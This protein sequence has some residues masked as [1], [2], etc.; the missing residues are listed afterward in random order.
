[1]FLVINILNISMLTNIFVDIKKHNLVINKK[2]L[3]IIVS[4]DIIE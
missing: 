2:L 3:E 4:N 1:M